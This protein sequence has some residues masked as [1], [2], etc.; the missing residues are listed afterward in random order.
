LVASVV[1]GLLWDHVSHAAVFLYGA[2]FAIAGSIAFDGLGSGDANSTPHITSA[3]GT[4]RTKSIAA[5]M[6]A[7][8]PKRTLAAEGLRDLGL[9]QEGRSQVLRA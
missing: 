8:D 1:A 4:K 9:E 5:P 2:A 6:S 7:A 3:F